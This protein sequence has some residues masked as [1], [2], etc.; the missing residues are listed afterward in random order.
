MLFDVTLISVD[1]ASL[2]LWA[3]GVV[4]LFAGV[5]GVR[6]LFAITNRS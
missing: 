1:W 2:N 5:W 3:G 6:K 4:A